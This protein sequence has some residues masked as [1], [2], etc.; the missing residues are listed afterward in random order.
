MIDELRPAI[1]TKGSGITGLSGGFFYVEA[2]QSV[3]DNY[4][5]FSVV[6]NTNTRDTATKFEKVFL[7][8]NVYSLSALTCETLLERMK[9]E[10]DDSEAEFS[11]TSYHLIRIERNFV[12]GLFKPDEFYQ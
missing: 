1:Y 10:F 3:T 5:V 8:I 11:L 6:T 12:R 9:D 7:Q 4:S 2:P